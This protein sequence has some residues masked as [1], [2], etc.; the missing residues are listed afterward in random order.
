MDNDKI[1]I[2]IIREDIIIVTKSMLAKISTPSSPN[3]PTI[4]IQGQ[5]Y[6][7]TS[8]TAKPK[9]KLYTI[10]DEPDYRISLVGRDTWELT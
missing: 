7:V 9:A 2:K 6:F 10:N 5:H 4:D 8:W 1:R 3:A